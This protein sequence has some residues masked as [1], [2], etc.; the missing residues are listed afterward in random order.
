MAQYQTAQ[1]HFQLNFTSP[2]SSCYGFVT[3]GSNKIFHVDDVNEFYKFL[4]FSDAHKESG[5]MPEEY[6]WLEYRK[7]QC[8]KSY[9][10]LQHKIID[11]LSRHLPKFKEEYAAQYE[12]WIYRCHEQGST[13]LPMCAECKCAK[14]EIAEW[15]TQE[16]NEAGFT[17]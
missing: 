5:M 11:Y 4:G 15:K 1:N 7:N 9:A 3:F 14:A 8:N 17:C 13:S 6:L 10:C 12:Y 2:S 16:S